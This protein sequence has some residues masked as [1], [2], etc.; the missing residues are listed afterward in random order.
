MK[1]L[2]YQVEKCSAVKAT[3]LHGGLGF[4]KNLFCFTTPYCII[5]DPGEFDAISKCRNECRYV[6]TDVRIVHCF[7]FLL[8]SNIFHLTTPLF[9]QERKKMQPCPSTVCFTQAAWRPVAAVVTQ[10]QFKTMAQ[11]LDLKF[12]TGGADL[13]AFVKVLQGSLA[14]AKKILMLLFSNR[15]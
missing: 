1:P 5:Q 3:C 6:S 14:T 10:K 15:A 7:V 12:P 11:T 9:W 2:I 4:E 8:F 13:I